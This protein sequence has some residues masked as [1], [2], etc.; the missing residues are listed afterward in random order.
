MPDH[1]ASPSTLLASFCGTKKIQRQAGPPPSNFCSRSGEGKMGCKAMGRR[2]G[3]CCHQPP[4]VPCIP[5]PTPAFLWLQWAGKGGGLLSQ[6]QLQKVNVTLWEMSRKFKW[7]GLWNSHSDAALCCLL[8][9]LEPSTRAGFAPGKGKQ[10]P[11][12]PW[13]LTP[14]QGCGRETVFTPWGFPPSSQPVLYSE[15][16]G[17]CLPGISQ[18]APPFSQLSATPQNLGVHMSHGGKHPQFCYT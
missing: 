9:F 8:P 13:L 10:N 1:N 7:G 15:K 2:K 3:C 17:A 14:L 6:P 5:A 4:G 12:L 18:V 16:G 11:G